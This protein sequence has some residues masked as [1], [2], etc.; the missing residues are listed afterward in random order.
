MKTLE[1]LR[2]SERL[3]ENEQAI[4]RY[5]LDHPE[6]VTKLSS[7]ELARRTLTSPTAVLRFCKKLGFENYNEFKVNIVS[8]LKSL[9]LASTMIV[10]DEPAVNA[11]NKLAVLEAQVI[12]ETK[13]KASPE[14]LDAIATRIAMTTY[15]DFFARDVNAT[16]ASYASHNFL[17]A[18]R[19]R[20]VTASR[21]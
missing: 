14:A 17:L 15:V 9:D 4:A 19:R 12:E 5:V 2:S 18:G 7:R 3:T 21:A 13:R 16:V 10:R 11:L 6:E 8:E 1:T 20:I